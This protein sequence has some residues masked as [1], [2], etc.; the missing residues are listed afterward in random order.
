MFV[1]MPTLF[2]LAISVERCHGANSFRLWLYKCR[3]RRKSENHD[4]FWIW[5]KQTTCPCRLTNSGR[6]R[7]IYDVMLRWWLNVVRNSKG[8]RCYGIILYQYRPVAQIPQCI[9]HISHN[10]SFCNKNVHTRSHFC[11][12]MVHCGT[13]VWCIMGFVRWDYC[14]PL[15]MF[16]PTTL[17]KPI[18]PSSL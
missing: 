18:L 12:K 17:M 3:Q 16:R 10:A 2:L 5:V 4:N 7:L 6:Y 11:Y 14:R 13:F 8:H 15:H 9:S 1:M